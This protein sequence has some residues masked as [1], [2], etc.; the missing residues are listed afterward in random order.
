M[1]WPT[2]VTAVTTSVPWKDRDIVSDSQR[3]L[4]GLLKIVLR[5]LLVVIA[6]V[7]G[8]LSVVIARVLGQGRF[9][10]VVIARAI[11]VLSVVI[12]RVLLRQRR[13]TATSV[14]N[15]PHVSS[16]SCQLRSQELRGVTG[17]R[18]QGNTWISYQFSTALAIVVWDSVRLVLSCH[19]GNCSRELGEFVH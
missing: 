13:K 3:V 12:A 19:S 17:G 7:I 11:R 2:V 9:L 10:G 5:V 1:M 4:P 14:R 16:G 15:A 18:R 8:V 6:R